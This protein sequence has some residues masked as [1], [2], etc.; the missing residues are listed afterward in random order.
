MILPQLAGAAEY[1]DCFSVDGEDYPPP[2]SVLGMT[3][4]NLMVRL[5]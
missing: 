5:Q 1:I 4:N 3:L 2:T